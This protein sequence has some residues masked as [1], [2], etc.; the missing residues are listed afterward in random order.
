MRTF[1]FGAALLV[2]VV[3]LLVV[4]LV[5]KAAGFEIS[6]LGSLGLTVILTIIVNLLAGAMARRN[7]RF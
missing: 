6:L 7:R 3:L 4:W 2:S 1:G 5:G